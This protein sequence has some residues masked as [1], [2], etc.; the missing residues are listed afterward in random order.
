MKIGRF[1]LKSE[2]EE[3][4]LKRRIRKIQTICHITGYICLFASAVAM[5][6]IAGLDIM[7][8]ML[9]GEVASL[10]A[11][12]FGACALSMFLIAI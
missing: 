11:C 12:M 10:F 1:P 2:I 4:R 5:G 6:I 8:Y 7:P 9:S 3:M